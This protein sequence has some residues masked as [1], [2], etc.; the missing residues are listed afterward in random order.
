M[1]RLRE[2]AS[3]PEPQAHPALALPP[4]GPP[5]LLHCHPSPLRLPLCAQEVVT[6]ELGVPPSEIFSEISAEPVAAASLGQVYRAR[7]RG[8]GDAVAVKVQ[9]PGVLDQILLD[10]YIL[11][12]AAGIIRVSHSSSGAGVGAGCGRGANGLRRATRLSF[13]PRLHLSSVTSLTL[14]AHYH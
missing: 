10:I 1:A 3:L 11:R 9:R 6:Q 2:V 4:A 8:S 7:L 5:W 12:I 13:G 14:L